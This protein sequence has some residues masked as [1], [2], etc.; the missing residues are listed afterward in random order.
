MTDEIR[1]GDRV[2]RA[3]DSP[4]AGG[5]AGGPIGEAGADAFAADVVGAVDQE[6]GAP[7]PGSTMPGAAGGGTGVG[8]L[9]DGTGIGTDDAGND[10]VAGPPAAGGR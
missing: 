4:A 7:N 6:P 10:G 1:P 2:G 5:P 9:A 8:D 3:A